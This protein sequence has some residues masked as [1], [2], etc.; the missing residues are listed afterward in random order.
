MTTAGEPLPRLG[1]SIDMSIL[2]DF[3]PDGTKHTSLLS[4]TVQSKN[5]WREAFVL[6]YLLSFLPL[7][8][9]SH[10]GRGVEMEEA[11]K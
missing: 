5:N 3:T 6:R 4:N 2:V 9:L 1:Y 8:L 7:Q 11:I 10:L